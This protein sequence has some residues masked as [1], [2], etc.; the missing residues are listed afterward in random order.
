MSDA[1]KEM[2]LEFLLQGNRIQIL[3]IHCG[4]TLH[5]DTC[6]PRSEV[7]RHRAIKKLTERFA[8]IDPEEVNARLLEAA[9]PPVNQQN[10][11]SLAVLETPE[12]W[13]DPVDGALLLDEL[14][15]VIR[16]F[17]VLPTH[18]AEICALWI[19]HTFVFA[20]FEYTPRL[21]IHSPEKRCGKSR[22]L[23]LLAALTNRALACE[24][25]SPAALFRS[26][27][28]FAP[29][30]LLDEA[31]T[32]LRGRSVN[33]DL[34][35]V[36]N[37]GH[38]RGGTIL[39]C[40]GDDQEPTPFN[41]FAP[42]AI[43]MI[44]KPP[45]TIEDRSIPV[46]MRRR[47]PGETVERHAAGKSVRAR[48]IDVVRRC[49]R[50]STDNQS[51]LSSAE[52]A[53]PQEIDD[54]AADCWFA[55]LAIADRCGGQWPK[56]ARV[57]AI[58]V[59][60]GRDDASGLGV[61][62]LRDLRDVFDRNSADRMSSAGILGELVAME[63]R[64]WPEY[65]RGQPMTARQLAKVLEPFGITPKTIRLPNDTTP[66]GYL[67]VDLAD[68]WERYLGSDSPPTPESTATAPHPFPDKDLE[69]SASATHA[70]GVADG[71]DPNPLP[72]KGCGGVADENGGVGTEDISPRLQRLVEEL[73][74]DVDSLGS[75]APY[76]S[77]DLRQFY[78]DLAQQ[79][80]LVAAL[81]D[82][83]TRYAQHLAGRVPPLR[84]VSP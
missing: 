15:Q 63:D 3:L 24:G 23:R 50:W 80:G 69:P 64:P 10:H 59:M 9:N 37:A 51:A 22:L 71:N 36:I 57:M 26:I 43:A 65:Q 30:L 31:D 70:Q 11:G 33:E 54:R 55:L 46:S 28:K 58:D 47:L 61:Q 7:S 78:K 39:R 32:Y 4:K 77:L 13:P 67:R 25:I 40:V 6:D 41:C 12:P 8:S 21:L 2:A 18:A 27:D 17:V 44:G 53:L 56:N 49:V 79:I 29:T 52:P 66:K 82:A 45:G 48:F 1:P 72:D 38:Q 62:L 68:A 14:A 75:S 81:H 35:G 60:A 16:R 73:A 20:C 84:R 83:E 19:L 34:R 42:V 74:D 76:T 5:S